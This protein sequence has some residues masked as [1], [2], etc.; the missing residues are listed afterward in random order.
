MTKRDER[1]GATDVPAPPVGR[2]EFLHSA[3]ALSAAFAV[4][5]R[6]SAV[7]GRA[8]S[9][10]TGLGR[11]LPERSAAELGLIEITIDQLQE[12]M[13]SGRFTARSVTEAYLGRIAD[14]DR[15]GPKLRAVIET[16]PDAL[17]IAD[18][19]DAE[20]KARGPRGP[21]HGVPVL[22]K[23]AMDTA[24]R[25][26][27]TAGSLALANSFAPRD[28]FIVQRL[29][30]AGAVILGKTNLSEWSN[31]RS[32]HSAAGWSARGGLTRNPYVLDRSACGSSSGSGAAIAANL[33]AI[34]IG[35]ETDGSIVCPA[36]ANGLVAVKPTVGLW[37]R[38]GLIPVSYSQ[39]TAGPMC[40]TVR[41]AA[42]LLGAL[43]GVDPADA[44]TSGAAPHAQ[45]DFTATLDRDG[46][47]GVRLGL[48]RQS[49][50][51]E[52]PL[53]HVMDQSIA[54]LRAAG[55]VV[56]DPIDAGA[57]EDIDLPE[58][59]VLLYEFKASIKEYLAARGPGERNKS[60]ADLIRFNVDHRDVEMKFFGQEWFEMAEQTTGL[61]SSEYLTALAD[62]RRLSRAEGLDRIL[63][64]HQVD[65]IVSLTSGPAWSSD[66]LDGDH[67]T[68]GSSSLA[69][70]SGYPSV[71][72]PAGFVYGLPVGVSFIGGAWSEQKLLRY[73]YAFERATKVRQAPRFLPTINLDG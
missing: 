32:T 72:V 14:L 13:R 36:S 73:A 21:L 43:A 6:F 17:R 71:T 66:V 10:L 58:L 55:A 38:T 68:I 8:P 39:D 59:Q 49:L 70:V 64:K 4:G 41:D 30:A 51:D 28:A 37:S 50:P 26:R 20:R 42:I 1:R 23:D 47:R 65:A 62:C 60:L 48:L 24:D 63:Q 11:R 56:I 27:S 35:T 54:A 34:G 3:A 31:F 9:I 22:I 46:L 69:A 18:Q 19:M 16:N 61:S 15:A 5:S 7:S 25:M 53:L 57:V 44:A 29:R 67:N 40:R 12:G 45:T 52:S 2:R 33:G